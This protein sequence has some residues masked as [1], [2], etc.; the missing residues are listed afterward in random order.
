MLSREGVQASRWPA[1]VTRTSGELLGRRPL[2]RV[3]SERPVVFVLGPGQVG[4]T[5]VARRIL[6]S[7]VVEL[8][9]PEVEAALHH[10][11]RHGQFPDVFLNASALLL[12][13]LDY[14]ADRHGP[15]QLLGRLLLA[16]SRAGT[17][18]VVCQGSDTSCTLLAGPIP[19]DAR[20]TLLLRFPVGRGRRRFVVGRCRARGVPLALVRGAIEMEPWTYDAVEAW[21]DGVG[22]SPPT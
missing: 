6:G 20:A 4:K 5:S 16:R 9:R 13:D 18:T 3:I 17:R 19:H 12:D 7:G 2:P 22:Q 1:L 11:A 15:L 8:G 14:L 10:A 21:L